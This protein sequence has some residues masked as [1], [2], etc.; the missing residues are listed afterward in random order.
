[1]SARGTPAPTMLSPNSRRRLKSAQDAQAE[2]HADGQA[3]ED[4]GEDG[5]P[6][7]AAAAAV[8]DVGGA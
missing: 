7:R 5:P 6:P 3:D 1:M 8:L 4:R 2:E